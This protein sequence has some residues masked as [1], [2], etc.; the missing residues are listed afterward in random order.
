MSP[1]GMLSSNPTLLLKTIKHDI[2]HPVDPT[3]PKTEEMF[4]MKPRS[5]DGLG[6]WLI[7]CFAAALHPWNSPFA[8]TDMVFPIARR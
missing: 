6:P 4:I 1:E 3:K 8:L 7:I 5:P 2:P